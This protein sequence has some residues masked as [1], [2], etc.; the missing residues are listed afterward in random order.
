MR[1]QP[2]IDAQALA[3]E[4]MRYLAAVDAF[5]MVGCEP[6]WWPESTSRPALRAEPHVPLA[7][8]RLAH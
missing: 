5:R 7:S 2:H 4:I 3:D 8:A 6:T 1:E